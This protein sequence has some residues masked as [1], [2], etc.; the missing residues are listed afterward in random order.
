M[1]T[2]N[3]F[4]VRQSLAPEAM[5]S[6]TFCWTPCTRRRRIRYYSAQCIFIRR[7]RNSSPPSYPNW[8]PLRRSQTSAVDATF[9]LVSSESVETFC[10]GQR[11]KNRFA[12]TDQDAGDRTALTNWGR[13]PR[14][15]HLSGGSAHREES[16]KV[17]T[18]L[19]SSDASEI[20]EIELPVNGRD[21]IELRKAP[22]HDRYSSSDHVDTCFWYRADISDADACSGS[23]DRCA[24]P[25]ALDPSWRGALRGG[26][27]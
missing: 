10:R 3:R 12:Y 9:Y 23:A 2:Q 25:R 20:T 11:W 17:A 8:N 26:G 7:L 5:K 13:P 22:C 15:S 18:V 21:R 27:T 4:S 19:A 1:L 14:R 16:R 24:W 6:F